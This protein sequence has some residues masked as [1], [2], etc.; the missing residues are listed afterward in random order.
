MQI[1]ALAGLRSAVS[2]LMARP[3]E[4]RLLRAAVCALARDARARAVAPERL[5]VCFKAVWAEETS[6]YPVPDRRAHGAIF[7]QMVTLCIRE[8][9]A[10]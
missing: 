4:E 10:A 5:L 3:A 8:Y 9:F 7:D 1:P 6:A 2:E